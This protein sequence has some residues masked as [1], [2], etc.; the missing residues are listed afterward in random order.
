[1]G[2]NAAQPIYRLIKDDIIREIGEGAYGTDQCLPSE[3]DLAVRYSTTRMTVRHA[4]NYL[5]AGG[6][7][8]RLQGKG[9][10]VAGTKLIQPLMQVTGF[11]EDMLRRGKTPSSQLMFAGLK[12]ADHVVAN[13]LHINL[14][15]DYILIK[16]L[17]FADGMPMA[18]EATALSYELCSAILD[19]DLGRESM[20]GR[21]RALG[22]KLVTGDQY[23]EA[24]LADAEQAE[25]LKIQKGAPV[26]HI[27]RHV[28]NENGQPVE[29]T[30]STY[31]G[32]Q[33]RFFV[34]FDSTK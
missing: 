11:T 2:Q 17:R 29:A 31:R 23:M 13:D 5:E 7:V 30:Y 18:I 8:Y 28:A 4:L 1:M 24:A 20:Y 3:R 12:K 21:L 6:I 26:M 19:E 14:G 10:F 16:R 15:Q 22:L 9:T 34:N 27:E 32:D 33:Y 25:L